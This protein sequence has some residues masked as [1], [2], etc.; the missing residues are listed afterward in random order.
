MDMIIMY[1]AFDTWYSI[2]FNRFYGPKEWIQM[3]R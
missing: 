1:N 3:T 2:P